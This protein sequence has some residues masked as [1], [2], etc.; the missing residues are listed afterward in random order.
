LVALGK[1]SYSLYLW[2]WPVVAATRP[3]VDVALDGVSLLALRLA[4]TALLAEASYRLVETPLRNGRWLALPRWQWSAPLLRPYA[5]ALLAL[6]LITFSAGALISAQEPPPPDLTLPGPSQAFGA[7]PPG[8]VIVTSLAGGADAPQPRV[9]AI[10]DSVML[11]ARKFLRSEQAQVEVDA[12]VG[13]T[14]LT[15]LALLKRRKVQHALGDVVIIHLGNN[16]PFQHEQFDQMMELL[17]DVPHV[18]FVTAKVPRRLG[19]FNNRTI[20]EG[21]TRHPR[22]ALIDWFAAAQ[23]HDKWFREDGLHLR[24]SGATEYARLLAEHYL[25]PAAAPVAR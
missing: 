19:V 5:T 15:T 2:H 22:A 17:G 16:G 3:G 11:G 7:P 20:R 13:R 23:G 10:G 9:L 1:R 24:E 6:V 18:A 14:P 25:P 21:V 8:Q 12:E 4:L